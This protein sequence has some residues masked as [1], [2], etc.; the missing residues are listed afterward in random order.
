MLGI[1]TDLTK[2]IRL[3]AEPSNEN[4]YRNLSD[5]SLLYPLYDKKQMYEMAGITVEVFGIYTNQYGIRFVVYSLNT[6]QY[7][8]RYDL[9]CQTTIDGWW[10]SFS[11]STETGGLSLKDRA[12]VEFAMNHFEVGDLAN[13]MHQ[14]RKLYEDTANGASFFLPKGWEERDLGASNGDVVTFALA[15]ND[16]QCIHYIADDIWGQYD[17]HTQQALEAKGIARSDI[18]SSAYSLED[19][20]SRLNIPVADISRKQIGTYEFFVY[21]QQNFFEWNGNIESE[22]TR[23]AICYENGYA[24]CFILKD[25]VESTVG[26]ERLELVLESLM[27]Y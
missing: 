22:T 19:V 6:P 9:F 7:A 23:G 4:D 5:E 10:I 12:T 1:T 8:E 26:L 17:A 21:E 14:E 16:Y 11:L 18:N 15:G 27:L 13:K 2:T 25:L 24:Y 3:I 20:A